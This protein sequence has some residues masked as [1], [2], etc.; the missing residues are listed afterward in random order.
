MNVKQVIVIRRDLGMR[1][2]KEIAQGSHASMAFLIERLKKQ[3]MGEMQGQF[4]AAEEAWMAG[5]FR[6]IVCQVQTEQELVELHQVARGLGVTSHLITDMGATE[7]KGVPTVT[8][9]ALGPWTA[10][11]LDEITSHLKLY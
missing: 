7:F 1:R 10:E 9:L 6:K 3:P 2:G 8:A 11:H 4:S 5:N